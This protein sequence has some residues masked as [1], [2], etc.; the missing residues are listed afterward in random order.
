MSSINSS[1]P[2]FTLWFSCCSSSFVLGKL[3]SSV[4]CN[5]VFTDIYANCSNKVLL[6]NIKQKILLPEF[7]DDIFTVMGKKKRGCASELHKQILIY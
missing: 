4:F 5:N 3:S 7:L 6:I 1:Q 2:S